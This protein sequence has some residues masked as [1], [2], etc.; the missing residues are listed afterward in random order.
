MRE[1][2]LGRTD[3]LVSEVGF[4]GIPIIP[5]G[6]KEAV[7]VVRRCFEL[8][9]TLF[10]T[11]NAYRDSEQKIGT[12]LEGVKDRVVLAT[13][14]FE[15]N[16][17]GAA[18][19]IEFSLKNLKTDRI[20]LYQIHQ[21][22]NEETLQQVLGPEGAFEAIDKARSQG[23]IR[24]VGVTS[25]NI[26]AAIKAC[27]T[28]LFDTVQI[29]F[30]FIERDPA[31]ELFNV[32]EALDMGIIAMKPLGGGLLERADLCFRFLQQ[33]PTVVP[34]AGIKAREE[35]E[36][37]VEIYRAPK[38]LTEVDLE[39]IDRIRNTLGKK[40]CH[41]CEYCMPCEQGVQIPM[42]LGFKTFAG[43]LPPSATKGLLKGAMKSI[44]RCIECG[45][46]AEKC[47]Y[48]LEIPG[49]LKE[50]LALFREYV[51]KPS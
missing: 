26:Q 40:F 16:A 43:Q 46:C 22:G 48:E 38:P 17:K 35:A 50:N 4:G 41:R 28:G 47:P 37:I 13:K 45:R 3:L 23:I 15:R 33:C 30:N 32:A 10:D 8:G 36:E 1:V 31:E 49:L 34:I 44:G 12:A 39:D 18:K 29:P 14:T 9:M 20:D 24:F 42:V 5:L 21:L 19:H 2:R 25:H 6:M 11:A 51:Q 7:A 27:N